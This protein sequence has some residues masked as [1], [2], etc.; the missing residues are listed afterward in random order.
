MICPNCDAETS[1]IF[2]YG[3][4]KKVCTECIYKETSEGKKELKPQ[5]C[6]MCGGEVEFVNSYATNHFHCKSFC[7]G[8]I[9]YGFDCSKADAIR[10]YNRLRLEDE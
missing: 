6:L 5:P 1:V 10:W 8:F 4:G 7:C 2:E 3:N 9:L